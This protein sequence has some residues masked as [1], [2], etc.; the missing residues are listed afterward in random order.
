LEQRLR[1]LETTVHERDEPQTLVDLARRVRAGLRA[2]GWLATELCRL[3][4]E[5]RERS[6]EDGGR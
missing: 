1:L 6:A 5:R 2:E 3:V 4:S